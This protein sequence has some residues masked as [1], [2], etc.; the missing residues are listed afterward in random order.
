MRWLQPVRI[1]GTTLEKFLD[2]VLCVVGAILFSQLPEFFQQYLQR[3]GGHLDEARRQLDQFKDTAA[4]SGLT[5]DRLIADTKSQSEPA[6]A[7][8]GQVM[9]ETAARVDTLQATADALRGASLWSR[10]FVFLRHLDLPIA[11]A[12]WSAFRPGVPT[13][14]EGLV[15]AAAGMGVLLALYYGAVRYPV[16]RAWRRRAERRLA[17]ANSEADPDGRDARPHLSREG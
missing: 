10:P 3:L 8:L 6:V 15:Y 12:T 2:R 4:Q 11:R 13:T 16:T 14:F 1:L 17:A 7:H 5:L 9:S